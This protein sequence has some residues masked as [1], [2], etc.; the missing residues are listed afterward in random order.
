MIDR[1]HRQRGSGGRVHGHGRVVESGVD[2]VNRDRIVWVCGVARH[3]ADDGE[4]AAV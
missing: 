4:G 3:V 1:D 2:V